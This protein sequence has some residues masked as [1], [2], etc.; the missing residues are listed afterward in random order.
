MSSLPER[1]QRQGRRRWTSSRGE[2]VKLNLRSCGCG[3]VWVPEP[4]ASKA[5][6]VSH[7]WYDD[8]NLARQAFESDAKID[9]V[10]RISSTKRGQKVCPDCS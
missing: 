2:L 7:G 9:P 1:R 6:G 3:K 8:V 5:S 10:I 4:Q